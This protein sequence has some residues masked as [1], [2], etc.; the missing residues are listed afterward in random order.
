M[1]GY[2]NSEFYAIG[3][4]ADGTVGAAAISQNL[5]RRLVLVGRVDKRQRLAAKHLVRK[6]MPEHFC[7]I[8]TAF[9]HLC[10]VVDTEGGV[11]VHRVESPAAQSRTSGPSRNGFLPL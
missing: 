3:A 10:A 5:P 1:R 8:R 7:Q 6:L 11:I 2:F 9:H 4:Q